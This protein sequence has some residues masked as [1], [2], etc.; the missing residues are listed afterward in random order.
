M[1]SGV[2]TTGSHNFILNWGW[3]ENIIISVLALSS[4]VL[5]P[6]TERAKLQIINNK[7][8]YVC[9]SPWAAKKVINMKLDFLLG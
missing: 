5:T 9:Y 4:F 8:I 1:T 7:K 2:S 6:Q 3:T